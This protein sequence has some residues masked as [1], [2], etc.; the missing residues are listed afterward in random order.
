MWNT[1]TSVSDPLR[2]PLRAQGRRAAHPGGGEGLPAD[3]V[4]RRRS[5]WPSRAIGFGYLVLGAVALQ[6]CGPHH[7][8]APVAPYRVVVD[9]SGLS[10]S[11]VSAIVSYVRSTIVA[12]PGAEGMLRGWTVTVSPYPVTL[13]SATINPFDG[14]VITHAT[15]YADFSAQVMGLTWQRVTSGGNATPTLRVEDEV[16]ELKNVACAC[17]SGLTR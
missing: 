9:S 17:E 15:S 14:K 5:W 6:A 3:V 4:Q 2:E 7:L 12:T 11:Q 13:P 8:Q 16:Y 10:D 1:A